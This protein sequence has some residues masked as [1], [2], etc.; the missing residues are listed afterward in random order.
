MS[1]AAA[2][3]VGDH[4]HIEF[5][6]SLLSTADTVWLRVSLVLAMT[7]FTH[8]WNPHLHTKQ[9]H[10]YAIQATPFLH[11]ELS[12]LDLTLRK[13]KCAMDLSE[14]QGSIQHYSHV[15]SILPFTQITCS[16]A[17]SKSRH[18]NNEIFFIYLSVARTFTWF[19]PLA[20]Q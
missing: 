4:Q 18:L 10:T 14:S 2:L 5:P 11:R 1:T 13:I 6:C 17:H 19:P 12:L 15:V 16:Y 20:V 7:C 8:K 9:T 3:H